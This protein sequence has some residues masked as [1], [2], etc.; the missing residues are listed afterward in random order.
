MPG[1]FIY[2]A[3]LI[4]PEQPS[5]ELDVY[6]QPIMD[7]PREVPASCWYEPAVQSE[8]MA[9]KDM[10]VDAYIVYLPEGTTVDGSA[11]I[12]IPPGEFEV[13]G[14]PALQPGGFVLPGHV[15]VLVERVRG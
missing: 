4:L 10:Q 13:Q 15:R 3:V 12:R 14:P 11:A 1:M 9:S 6:N 8:D 2:P 5:G 7:P